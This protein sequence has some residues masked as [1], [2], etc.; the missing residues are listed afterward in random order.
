MT[1]RRLTSRFLDVFALW[2]V[3][4]IQPMLSILGGNTEYFV[5]FGVPQRSIIGFAVVAVIA[6]PVLLTGIV[7]LLARWPR[8][9]EVWHSSVV[10][11]LGVLVVGQ[12]LKFGLSLGGIVYVGV[13]ATLTALGLLLWR[14]FEPL[15]QW[16]RFLAVVPLVSASLFVLATPAGRY[17]RADSSMET[18]AAVTDVPV[19]M[20]MFDEFPVASLLDGSGRI[21]AVRF[22]HFARLAGMSTWYRQATTESEVTSYAVPAALSGV[23]PREGLSATWVDHPRS[24]FSLF[25]DSHDLNVSETVTRMCDPTRCGGEGPEST[26][27]KGFLWGLARLYRQRVDTTLADEFNAVAGVE[28]TPDEGDA[29]V[30]DTSGS[31]VAPVPGVGN[32]VALEQTTRFRS[33]LEQVGDSDDPQF[34]YVHLLMPHQP[35]VYL[36]SGMN[37]GTDAL[38]SLPDETEWETRVFRQR[39]LFQVQH[40]DR[41]VGEL[42]DRLQSTGILEEAMVVVTADHGVALSHGYA[43]RYASGDYANAREIMGV[44]LFVKS[45]GRSEA[46]VSDANVQT[47]DLLPLLAD[48]L[49]IDVPWSMDGVAPA[50]TT[51]D[52]TATKTLLFQ[53]N[54]FNAIDTDRAEDSHSIGAGEYADWL[55]RAGS[56]GVPGDPVAWLFDGLDLADLRGRNAP[57]L[58]AGRT[59]AEVVLDADIASHPVKV[60]LRGEVRGA[61]SGAK[62]LAV[63]DRSGRILAVAPFERPGAARRFVTVVVTPEGDWAKEQTYWLIAGDG[64]LLRI[65][66]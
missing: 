1:K 51:L 22:P 41:L 25:A 6:V 66:G 62:G 60:L 13:A 48:V 9:E 20:V 11:G 4:V 18:V 49:D 43:R 17:A 54:R 26:D 34:S 8:V 44:P 39:H 59:E 50:S 24:V 56:P 10:A 38:E 29:D 28:G 40:A 52:R 32:F 5:R 63:A 42:L 16:M 64:S 15:R 33:W 58:S 35:W 55:S 21:D 45:P 19:V 30:F 65:A 12:V 47:T 2:G 37:Y 31:A 27:W 36:P 57:S 14:R 7:A 23:V 46:V 61:P 53:V 3:A